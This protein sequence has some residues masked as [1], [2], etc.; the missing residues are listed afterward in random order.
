[1]VGVG[2]GV[3]MW[4]PG[5]RVAGIFMQNWLD[6]PLTPAKAKGALGGDIDGVLAEYVLFKETGL[7]RL[8]E[9]L[10]FQEAATLPCAA[11]TAWNA[12]AAGNLRPGAT[13]LIQGTGGVSL[14]ALQ[15]ARL[16]GA[17]VLGIS[18]SHTKL[19]RA[20]AQGLDAGLNYLENPE[21]DRWAHDETGG[22][23][24][25]LVIEVGGLGTLPRSLRAVRHGGTIAQVGVLA[26]AEDL[27]SFQIAPIL[28]KQIKIQGIYVGSR[29][30]FEDLNRAI[31]L[32]ILRP[33][34]EN[35]HWSQAR[36]AL[37]RMEEGSHFG[38][39]VL[40]VG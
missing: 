25:D 33:V 39:L 8:P 6:G 24:V 13:V 27:T 21:W 36:E 1:V 28:H 38:K 40:T 20:Y 4:K 22:E 15:L 18:S 30:D 16:Q 19:E 9:H 14:F 34:G 23:G 2:E 26:G 3:T 5:D 12:L 29:Q 17:R 7:I 35:F 10:S 31:S 11:V 32:A 37:A